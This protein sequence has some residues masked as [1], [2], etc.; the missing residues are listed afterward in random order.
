MTTLTP[1]PSQPIT[2]DYVQADEV[3]MGMTYDELSNFGIC[4]KNLKLGAYSMFQKLSHEWK[5]K[6]KPSEVAT[7][8]KVSAPANTSLFR[9]SMMN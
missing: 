1:S 7:K 3:D 2:K 6:M 8:V 4:R 9:K 5:G